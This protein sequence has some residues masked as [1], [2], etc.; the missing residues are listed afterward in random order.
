MRPGRPDAEG[1]TDEETEAEDEIES[2]GGDEVDRRSRYLG[3]AQRRVL[4]CNRSDE[5]SGSESCVSFVDASSRQVF[6]IGTAHESFGEA[7][8]TGERDL[9]GDLGPPLGS[10]RPRLPATSLG[11]EWG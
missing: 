5:P 4:R 1:G 9:V 7:G 2:L 11:R 6:V 10:R 3:N 8:P